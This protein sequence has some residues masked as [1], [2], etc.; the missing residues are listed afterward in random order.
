VHLL[1]SVASRRC[2]SMN[3]LGQRCGK[4]S[5]VGGFVCHIHG[6]AVPMVKAA[7]QERLRALVDPSINA[8]L[9]A[10]TLGAPCDK[11]GRSDDMA[12]VVRA[13]QVVLDRTGHGPH[14][15]LTV[16]RVPE[17]DS[18]LTKLTTEQLE[19]AAEVMQAARLVAHLTPEELAAVRKIGVAVQARVAQIEARSLAAKALN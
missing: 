16:E 14:T 19:G 3:R 2:T 1:G 4:T 6:G 7:A 17:P 8:L 11:C 15:K 10:L 12:V 18:D 9:R 5:I 13:A